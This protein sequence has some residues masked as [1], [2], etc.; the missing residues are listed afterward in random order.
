MS[1]K[2]GNNGSL[3]VGVCVG[4]TDNQQKRQLRSVDKFISDMEKQLQE[5]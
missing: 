2:A 3:A 1:E 5:L 4:L